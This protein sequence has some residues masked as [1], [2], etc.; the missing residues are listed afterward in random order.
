M[1]PR[2]VFTSRWRLDS[3]PADVWKLLVDVEQWPGWWRHARQVR[4]VQRGAAT[5]IGDVT[6]VQ[7][8]VALGCPVRLRMHTVAVEP[9][10][11]IEGQATGDLSG[12]GLWTL[13]PAGEG[14]V[15]VGFRWEAWLERRWL[16]A[17]PFAV[18]PLFAWNHFV[19]MRGAA[20]GMS[21]H[22]GCRWSRHAEWAGAART[23]RPG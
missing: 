23:L 14:A 17:L 5:P 20:R 8:R 18:A 3:P 15:D 12:V 4:R 22:L 11:L 16:A 21:G 19:V 10:R 1:A 13:D 2:F 9:L 7:W 6:D